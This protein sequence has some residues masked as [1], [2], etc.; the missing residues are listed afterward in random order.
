MVVLNV[1]G[2]GIVDVVEEDL[3]VVDDFEL[4]VVLD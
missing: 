3:G 4:L 1:V 2:V